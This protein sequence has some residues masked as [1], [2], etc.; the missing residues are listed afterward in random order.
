MGETF[1]RSL[2]H[3]A[4][5]SNFASYNPPYNPPDA[6]RVPIRELQG[7]AFPQF[8]VLQSKL[9]YFR[10]FTT[11]VVVVFTTTSQFT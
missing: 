2:A 3:A 11:T 9:D 10:L 1:T 4:S 5:T 7:N 8:Y 6:A